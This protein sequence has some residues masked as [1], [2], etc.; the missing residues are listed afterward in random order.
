MQKLHINPVFKV[1]AASRYLANLNFSDHE[2]II[3]LY[4]Q[5]VCLL[6]DDL[7]VYLY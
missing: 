6:M 1:P 2:T 3:I 4:I 7:Q 5:L